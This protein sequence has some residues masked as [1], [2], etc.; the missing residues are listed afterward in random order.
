MDTFNNN[1]S[2]QQKTRR[3]KF[4]NKLAH[5]REEYRRKDSVKQRIRNL[6]K[7]ATKEKT[8]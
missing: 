7:Q 6:V 3:E 2:S 5:I 1:T 8:L 4:F